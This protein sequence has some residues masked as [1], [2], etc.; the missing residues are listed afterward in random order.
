AC[1]AAARSIENLLAQSL[2]SARAAWPPILVSED[3]FLPYLAQ[4]IPQEES[5]PIA[6][7]RLRVTDLY[8]ACACAHGDAK[9][10][11][12]L[13]HRYLSKIAPALGKIGTPRDVIE[14]VQQ[15]LRAYL[16]VPQDGAEPHMADFAGRGELFAW[17]RVIALREAFRIR[18]VE[19]RNVR[20]GG[21][22]ELDR[23]LS[24][25]ADAELVYLKALYRAEFQE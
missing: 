25:A 17:L 7:A 6:L 23:A 21:E 15:F 18:S 3:L 5:V 19:R 8:L 12:E 4:R 11:V 16:L 9:A 2:R 24:V 10:I 20:V 13:E 22:R 14:E 1:A